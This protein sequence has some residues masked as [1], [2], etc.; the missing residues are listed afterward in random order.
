MMNGEREREENQF[1]LL[2]DSIKQ[3]QA[4]EKMRTHC[5]ESKNLRAHQ[6]LGTAI[7]FLF[8]FQWS[9]YFG[10]DLYF[11]P[12]FFYPPISETKEHKQ[13]FLG[14]KSCEEK[15]FK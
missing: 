7:H 10:Q 12:C 8:F 2:S 13:L 15:E 4:R 1:R 9:K 3:K 11:H 5:E 6:M 14:F